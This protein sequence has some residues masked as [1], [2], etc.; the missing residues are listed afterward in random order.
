ME[1]D[2]AKTEID[3]LRLRPVEELESPNEILRR[4]LQRV[5]DEKHQARLPTAHYTHHS[6]HAVHSN[7]W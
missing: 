1:Q 2:D 5:R 4:A 3:D 6:S 7:G